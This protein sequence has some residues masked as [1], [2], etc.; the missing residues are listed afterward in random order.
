MALLDGRK[1]VSPLRA[2]PDGIASFC[3]PS[4]M[5][6]FVFFR[7]SEPGM[8]SASPDSLFSCRR[9][10]ERMLAASRHGGGMQR[11]MAGTK[12]RAN[13]LPAACGF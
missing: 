5:S 10:R 9:S 4:R 7:P 3:R 2:S 1:D 12:K 13:P 8:V 6:R 11:S